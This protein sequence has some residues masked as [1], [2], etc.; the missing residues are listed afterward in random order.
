MSRFRGSDDDLRARFEEYIC[1]AL[2]TVKYTDFLAKGKAGDI[3]IVGVGR[4]SIPCAQ[5]MLTMQVQKLET[6]WFP[7]ENIGSVL[8]KIPRRML[9]G[10]R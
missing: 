4:S 2:S 5:C 6:R 1:A 9:F 7:L 8:S 10:I 3:S